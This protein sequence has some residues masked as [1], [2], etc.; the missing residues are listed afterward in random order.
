M[1]LQSCVLGFL[2]ASFAGCVSTPMPD[3]QVALP[4]S[5]QQ[6]TP[7]TTA[8]ASTADRSRWWQAFG[9]ARL[10]AL[11]HDAMDANL[12]IAQAAARL[13]AARALNKRADASL[14]PEV[15][16]RTSDPIDPDASA[17]YLVLGFDAI[18]ELGLFGRTTAVHRMSRGTLEGAQAELRDAQ[19]SVSAE[20]ARQW[21]L[22]RD[23]QQR[24]ATL[25]RIRGIRIRQSTLMT[26]R[27][28]LHL[29]SAQQ[30]AQLRLA[31]VQADAALA[32]PH[33]AA[34]AAA[35]ALAV[36]LGRA[37]PDQSWLQPG[38]IPSTDMLVVDSAPADLLRARP[39]V[40]RDQ[41]AVLRAAGELGVAKADMYPS[42]GLGGSIVGSFSEVERVNKNTGAIG[43]F[44]PLIDI[45]LFDWGMRR[46]QM[47]AKSESLQA[48]ALAYRKTVLTAVAEVE[49]ALAA[50][51]QQRLREHDALEALQASK[52]IA[53]ANATRHHLKLIS[54]IELAASDAD[55]EQ[56]VLELASV[57]ATRAI[58][59]IAL[60]KA[61]G[62]A[63]ATSV[64]AATTPVG[65]TR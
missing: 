27:I 21:I 42:I 35:Q 20:V 59:Y 2:V 65:G 3:L 63:P 5:Y 24:E 62:G 45:P 17:S 22:L 34:V 57:R 61:L 32:E 58:D 55:H 4:S 28:Q 1:K 31:T 13:R 39:D 60:C 9:D 10:D 52:E 7:G 16:F 23:A 14:R 51:E 15:H 36:L 53:Q 64:V 6:A 41:A 25:A 19:L 46:A 40:A 54:G 44:G 11:E 33:E 38:S 56:A 49:T 43:S 26:T 37:E 8:V 18:W 29:A 48:A 12:D 30:G 47:Q 50:S